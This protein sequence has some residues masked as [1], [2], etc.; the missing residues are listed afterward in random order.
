MGRD[1]QTITQLVEALAKVLCTLVLI[2]LFSGNAFADPLGDYETSLFGQRYETESITDRLSRLESSIFGKPQTGDLS[3]R[4][5]RLKQ[6]LSSII[7]EAQ[8]LKREPVSTLA[9]A[10]TPH[11]EEVT[12]YPAITAV[13]QVV[14]SRTFPHEDITKRLQRLELKLFERSFTQ[15]SLSD[16]VDQLKRRVPE[17]MFTAMPRTHTASPSRPRHQTNFQNNTQ[18]LKGPLVGLHQTLDEMEQHTFGSVSKGKLLTE[19]LDALERQN[20]RQTF[21]GESLETRVSRLQSFLQYSIRPQFPSS[22]ARPHSNS[23]YSSPPTQLVTPSTTTHTQVYQRQTPF[24][25]NTQRSSQSFYTS[26]P[27]QVVFQET[28]SYPGYDPKYQTGGTAGT[29]RSRRYTTYPYTTTRTRTYYSNPQPA[30]TQYHYSITPD[31][32]QKLESLEVKT[33]GKINRS[34]PLL[35]RLT[36]LELKLTGK[37]DSNFSP[38]ERLNHL[39]YQSHR[40]RLNLKNWPPF[41]SSASENIEVD[42]I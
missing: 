29:Q 16:R 42:P 14:Y 22:R 33:F 25:T 8:E 32:I 39:L 7:P 30:N 38:A 3:Q 36:R 1:K 35:T 28:Y 37:V 17:S 34:D 31:M 19:R 40:S 5:A 23:N 20:F 27:G 21:S 12:D 2:A 15:Q 10:T 41:S 13:E 6:V 9:P 11:R 4:E 26:A 18:E 24:G